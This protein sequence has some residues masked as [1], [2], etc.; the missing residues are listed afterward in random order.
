[1]VEI[2]YGCYF[3]FDLIKILIVYL[4]LLFVVVGKVVLN[5]F[6][7]F[8]D[9]FIDNDEKVVFFKKYILCRIKKV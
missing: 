1:M 4:W 6:K 3:I 8:V 7:V 5:M 9:G 2:C